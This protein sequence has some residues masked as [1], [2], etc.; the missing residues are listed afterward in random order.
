MSSLRQTS[1]HPARLALI[2]AFAAAAILCA[3]C[4]ASTLALPPELH[5]CE[6]DVL[7]QKATIQPESSGLSCWSIRSYFAG[8]PADPGRFLM[9]PAGKDP[10]TWRCVIHG[11]VP[12]GTTSLRCHI[13]RREFAYVATD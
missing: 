6:A 11:H 5:G 7:G 3:G 1:T 2:A 4:G 9:S 10:P 8:V 13:G 12:T